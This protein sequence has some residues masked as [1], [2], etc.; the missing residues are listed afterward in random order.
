[1]KPRARIAW[2]PVLLAGWLSAGPGLVACTSV[3]RDPGTDGFALEPGV[4]T[5]DQVYR[6]IG[7]P[8]A[9]Y[10]R[11]DGV[12]VLIYD[13]T[14]SQGL[15]VGFMVLVSRLMISSQQSESE[16]LWIDVSRDDVVIGARRQGDAAPGW[17]LWP[18]G[19]GSAD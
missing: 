18:G 10:E 19:E 12:R 15:G 16:A 14:R 2:L 6:Q 1:M 4:T 5:V 11:P 13:R 3:A 9:V 17:P 7:P 8:E